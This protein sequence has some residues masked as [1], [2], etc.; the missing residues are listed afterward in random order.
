M[1]QTSFWGPQNIVHEIDYVTIL[2]K[3]LNCKFMFLWRKIN[4]HVLWRAKVHFRY[5][6][7]LHGFWKT[8]HEVRVFPILSALKLPLYWVLVFIDMKTYILI[9]GRNSK[10]YLKVNYAIT[11][12]SCHLFTQKCL[13]W[14][15]TWYWQCLSSLHTLD[16]P[17]LCRR[18]DEYL[19]NL[20]S[21]WIWQ[22][23]SL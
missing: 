23:V 4:W 20:S 13:T 10:T 12:D 19:C 7:L 16:I 18:F 6:V 5:T 2:Y 1:H 22:S 8:Y 3:G 14:N 9:E 15:R 21:W 17:E 11:L